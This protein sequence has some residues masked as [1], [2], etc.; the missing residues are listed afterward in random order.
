MHI[1]LQLLKESMVETTHLLKLQRMGAE[2]E[3]HKSAFENL[4]EKLLES[5]AKAKS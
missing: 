5:A 3:A 2:L 1:Q 4:A